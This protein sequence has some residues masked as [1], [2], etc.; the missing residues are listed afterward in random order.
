M[1]MTHEALVTRLYPVARWSQEVIQIN[2]IYTWLYFR[3]SDGIF[4]LCNL[5]IHRSIEK[6]NIGNIY[7]VSV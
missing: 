4:I 5:K 2:S 7:T 3:H 6:L 1:I